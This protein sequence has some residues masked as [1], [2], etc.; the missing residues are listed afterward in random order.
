MHEVS[1]EEKH[2]TFPVSEVTYAV[3]LTVY[4]ESV[5]DVQSTLDSISRN[6]G[7]ENKTP[8]LKKVVVFL[9]IDGKDKADEGLLKKVHALAENHR[10]CQNNANIQ[11]YSTRYVSAFSESDAANFDLVFVVKSENRGKLDSH[12]VFFS[13][14]CPD[15]VPKYCLQVDAGSV[16]TDACLSEMTDTFNDERVNNVAVG[17]SVCIDP[18][19]GDGL[20]HDI[21]AGEFMVQSCISWPAEEFFGY[22]SVIPGQCSAVKWHDFVKPSADEANT[23]P[24]DRYLNNGEIITPIKKIMYLAED[25]IMGLELFSNSG[26]SN[27]ITYADHA[28]SYTDSCSTFDELIRQRR[29]WI[30]SGFSCRVWMILY[31]FRKML[32]SHTSLK[33]KAQ[34]GAYNLYAVALCCIELFIP[35]ILMN[36]VLMNH[37]A[38]QASLSP[39]GYGLYMSLMVPVSVFAISPLILALFKQS[40]RISQ[41][42][43]NV[44]LWCGMGAASLTII[45]MLVNTAGTVWSDIVVH[46]KLS[47]DFWVQGAMVACLSLMV[48][49]YLIANVYSSA[50]FS[51]KK[52]PYIIKYV[53]ASMVYYFQLYV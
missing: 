7:Y 52:S 41:R 53:L 26:P 45:A 27:T 39:F 22:L 48:A 10:C 43:M 30:N 47:S 2:K 29:R 8:C 15:I 42:Y 11:C 37:A 44:S 32:G 46:H 3:C 34:L 49:S 31:L 9:V 40:K 50:R 1:V 38:M 28:V 36:A 18:C 35:A 20:L 6:L 16:L 14:I 4:N 13:E 23:T 25:R 21:Q 12:R 33:R 19:S 17:S 24:M 5:G 51:V